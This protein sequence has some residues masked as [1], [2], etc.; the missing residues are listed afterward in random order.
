LKDPRHEL[1]AGSYRQELQ[2]KQGRNLEAR[3]EVEAIGE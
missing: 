2:R 3:A 1:Q